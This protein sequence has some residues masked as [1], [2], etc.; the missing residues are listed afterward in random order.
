MKDLK[1]CKK[2][3]KSRLSKKEFHILFSLVCDKNHIRFFEN[4]MDILI[5]VQILNKNYNEKNLLLNWIVGFDTDES[6]GV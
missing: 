6:S 4:F 5:F 1:Q 3:K 2:T